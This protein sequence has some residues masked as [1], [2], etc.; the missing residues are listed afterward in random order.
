NTWAVNVAI[1]ETDSRFG[2]M[3][4]NRE[5][6]RN[7]GLAHT[8]FSTRDGNDMAN[9]GDPGGANPGAAAACRRGMDINPH[10]RLTHAGETAQDLVACFLDGLRA[11]RII[12]RQRQLAHD[13]AVAR[14]DSLHQPKRDNIAAESGIFHRLKRFPNLIL[15]NSHG[16]ES[17]RASRLSK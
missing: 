3:E 2:L 11:R 5:V 17:Y 8:T 7:G 14:F 1:T 9:T 10:L 15:R 6:G 12:P 4:G 13:V 16:N